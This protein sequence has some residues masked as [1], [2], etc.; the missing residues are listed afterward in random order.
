MHMFEVS[1]FMTTKNGKHEHKR[2]EKNN[3]ENRISLDYD[4]GGGD[5]YVEK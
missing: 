4:D 3:I 5:M 2:E 1:L